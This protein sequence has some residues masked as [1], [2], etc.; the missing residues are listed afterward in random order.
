MCIFFV[1]AATATEL[2]FEFKNPFA[3]INANWL[4]LC[5]IKNSLNFQLHNMSIISNA[6]TIKR[7]KKNK[8]GRNPFF[9]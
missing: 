9:E 2:H 6:F 8:T 7:Q 1:R 5:D 4:A 3:L